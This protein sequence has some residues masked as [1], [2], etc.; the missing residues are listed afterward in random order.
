MKGSPVRVRASASL[1]QPVSQPEK[2]GEERYGCDHDQ[3]QRPALDRLLDEERGHD[4]DGDAEHGG[5]AVAGADARL[6]DARQVFH[7]QADECIQVVEAARL[8]PTLLEPSLALVMEDV[9]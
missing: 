6:E 1:E 3:P 4:T 8:P 9:R 7:P 2:H 5:P